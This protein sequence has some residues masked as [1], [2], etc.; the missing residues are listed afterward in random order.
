MA[1]NKHSSTKGLERQLQQQGRNFK[2]TIGNTHPSATMKTTS[3]R[4]VT[5]RD[6]FPDDYDRLESVELQLQT[7]MPDYKPP[8]DKNKK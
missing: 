1:K 2:P 3:Q 8:F 4:N 6:G 5:D 7:Q